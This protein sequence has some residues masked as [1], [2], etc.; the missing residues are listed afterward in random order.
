MRNTKNI[1]LNHAKI[2]KN[3]EFY[4]Q[5]ND[6]EKEVNNYTDYFKGKIVFCNCDN[7]KISSFWK[8]FKDNFEKLKLKRLIATYLDN[9]CSILTEMVS[10]G[11]LPPYIIQRKLEGNG[12]FRS[13]EV[14]QLLKSAD[15]VCTNPP[16]SLFIPYIQQ[17][18]EYKKDFLIIGNVNAATCN[19]IFSLFQQGKVWF[20]NNLVKEFI[21][22][23][24]ELKKFGNIAWYT[25]IKSK[26]KCNIG[27]TNNF[28]SSEYCK[29]SNFDAI[30]IDK[31]MDIPLDYYGIM[32][33]PVSFLQ[34]YNPDEF[35]ILGM[36]NSKNGVEMG[37]EEIG[38]EWIKLYK[39][40]G[41]TA[42]L[43]P[44]MRHLV[45]IKDGKAIYPYRRIIIK[46]KK[47]AV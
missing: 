27:L 10:L 37:V 4:T 38:D 43:T 12:D 31:L 25:N 21:Q 23:D 14:V 16:F 7:P 2:A 15:V 22:P 39:S 46:R 20:G 35:V 26:Q 18:V 29:Y 47:P 1:N 13:E 19:D 5:F 44:S 34:Y 9:N 17:L 6:I 32:G 28:N 30:N 40:Q 3:N 41:G 11:H 8:Y 36:S 24:G 33:V 42:H 45:Y